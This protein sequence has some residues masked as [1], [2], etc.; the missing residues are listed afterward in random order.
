MKTMIKQRKILTSTS[1]ECCINMGNK[2]IN[3]RTSSSRT[4]GF[5]FFSF[6]SFFLKF[7]LTLDLSCLAHDGTPQCVSLW[8]V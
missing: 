8:K 3:D 5:F 7:E 4:V 6:F 2:I 1:L